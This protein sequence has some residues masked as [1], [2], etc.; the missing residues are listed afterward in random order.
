[1]NSFS[2]IGRLTKKP[3]LAYTKENKAIV[4]MNVAI[5]NGKDDTTFLL[6]KSFGKQ[7]ENIEKYCDKGSQLAITGSIYNNNYEDKDGNRHYEYNFIAHTVEFISTKTNNTTEDKKTE[8][9]SKKESNEKIYEEFGN[10][11]EIDESELAF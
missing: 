3:E 4:K 11:L 6:I 2:I 9:E 8:N 10:Q 7:A 5:R 1:M